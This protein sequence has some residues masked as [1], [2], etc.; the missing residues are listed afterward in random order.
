MAQSN[1]GP[2]GCHRVN[3]M[4]GACARGGDKEKGIWN[5]REQSKDQATSFYKNLLG[6]GI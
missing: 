4:V 3:G 2:F 1:K 6:L 5:Q